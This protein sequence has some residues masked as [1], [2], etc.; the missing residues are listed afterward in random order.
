M[1]RH[2]SLHRHLRPLVTPLL[3]LTFLTLSVQQVQACEVE[4]RFGNP[5]RCTFMEE[6]VECLSAVDDSFI[7]CQRQFGDMDPTCILAA[8]FNTA[9]CVVEIPFRVALGAKVD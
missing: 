4:D 7:Q 2:T 9:A 3:A 8:A 6:F 1:D 5:R